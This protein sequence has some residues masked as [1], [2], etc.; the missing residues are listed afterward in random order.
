MWDQISFQEAYEYSKN[1]HMIVILCFSNEIEDQNRMNDLILDRLKF[2]TNNTINF[3]VCKRDFILHAFQK[4]FPRETIEFP[5]VVVMYKD[6]LTKL[7]NNEITR[8]KLNKVLRDYTYESQYDSQFDKKKGYSRFPN[9]YNSNYYHYDDDDD[10]DYYND[11]Y[12]NEYDEDYDNYDDSSYQED[13]VESDNYDYWKD[14]DYD[15]DG[16]NYEDEIES[17]QPL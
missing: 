10:Y 16:W 11:Y 3:L 9:I 2:Y 12:D 5:S 15:Y 14:Y 7:S 8:S 17:L 4:Y 1:Q 6:N 13:S